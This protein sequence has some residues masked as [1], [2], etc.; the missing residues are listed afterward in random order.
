VALSVLVRLRNGRYDAASLRPSLPEWPPHPA[1]LFCALVASATTDA[2]WAA[3]R[4]LE[5]AGEP[6]VWATQAVT[7]SRSA[8]YVVINKSGKGTSQFWPGRDNGRKERTSVLP[9][10]DGFAMVWPDATPD[11]ATLERLVRLARRVPYLGRATSSAEVTVVPESV[12]TRDGWA[13]FRPVPLDIPG[14]V[15]LRVP[16]PGYV[17]RLRDA[18]EAGMRSHLVTRISA[19]AAGADEVPEPVVEPV[20][21][22]PEMLVFG[23]C[24]PVVPL[25]GSRLVT[26]TEALRQAVMCRVP[27][28]L[29]P[30]VSGHGG[31]GVPR[32]AYLA[33]LDVGH[34]YADGHLLGVAVGLPRNLP[35]GDRRAVVRALIGD[36]DGLRT[37][38]IDRRTELKLEFDPDRSRPWGLRP[39]R[40][41]GPAEGSRTWATVTPVMLDRHPRRS[42]R[43]AQ[44]IAK[45]LVTAGYPVPISVEPLP[46]SAVA[47][48][49]HRPDRGSVPRGRPMHPM[50]H[51]R[52]EF[53][54]PVVGPVI[55]GSL[56]YRGCG[57]FV[58]EREKRA[59][60]E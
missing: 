6:E 29:P 53:P 36:G 46:G 11:A 33:L 31:D 52:V 23:V 39:E 45:C 4:W 10:D 17:D 57:L 26:V 16:F 12:V 19:Y 49:V 20:C 13:R 30:A 50:V 51:C 15:G 3:L 32:L 7:V 34:E 40:W 44:V 24:R 54:V 37:L 42:L 1:R 55:A 38:R 22:Y 41:S 28:P 43:A 27:D 18:Y 56:R 58:P 48:G 2:D 8:G 5:R 60:D 9:S 21:P 59:D 14:A 35:A 47:G 25:S